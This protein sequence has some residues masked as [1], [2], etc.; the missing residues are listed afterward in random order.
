[1][2]VSNVIVIRGA[3]RPNPWPNWSPSFAEL[4]GIH[5]GLDAIRV[6]K[7]PARVASERASVQTRCV[8]GVVR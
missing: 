2:F 4:A 8:Y 5:L 1:M 7:R 3:L 6:R